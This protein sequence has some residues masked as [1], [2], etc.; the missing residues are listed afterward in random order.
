MI[1]GLFRPSYI[2][3]LYYFIQVENET[4]ENAINFRINRF[5]YL[6][7]LQDVIEKQNYFKN[8]NLCCFFKQQISL[9]NKKYIQLTGSLRHLCFVDLTLTLL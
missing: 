3:I 4:L 5:S 2:Y 1:D 8:I 7:D 6:S 9:V